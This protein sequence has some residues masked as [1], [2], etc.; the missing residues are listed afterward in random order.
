MIASCTWGLERPTGI[1]RNSACGSI[2]LMAGSTV[3]FYDQQGIHTELVPHRSE[4]GNENMRAFL[5][6]PERVKSY[7]F[8][9]DYWDWRRS[10][11]NSTDRQRSVDT[12]MM[13]I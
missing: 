6:R 9:G 1:N 5:A 8:S 7:P 3:G 10:S 13:K 11:P 2:T 12:Q 4:G